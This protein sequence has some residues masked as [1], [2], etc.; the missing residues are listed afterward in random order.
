MRRVG[1][2]VRAEE[3]MVVAAAVAETRVTA[4]R[5][6]TAAATMVAEESAAVR[7]A[8]GSG[9]EGTARVAVGTAV[10]MAMAALVAAAAATANSD[11]GR[12]LCMHR[13]RNGPIYA[14]SP[15]RTTQ[16]R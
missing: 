6:G 13:C 8:A 7:A 2:A 12:N 14:R 11:K 9:L 15:D 3:A 4:A 10:A 1:A 5:V 16:R